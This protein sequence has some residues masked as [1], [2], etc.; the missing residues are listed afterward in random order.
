MIYSHSPLS[1]HIATVAIEQALV[2]GCELVVNDHDADHGDALVVLDVET[3]DE[4]GRVASGSAE[5]CVVFPSAGFGRDLY[6]CSFSTLARVS[7]V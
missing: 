4:R 3:G 1:H 2:A 6:Y 5:Q 7:V